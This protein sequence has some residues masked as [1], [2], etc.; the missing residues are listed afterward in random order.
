[1]TSRNHHGQRG[2]EFAAEVRDELQ[3]EYGVI[4]KLTTTQ[5]PQV[6]SMVERAHQTIHNMIATQNIEPKQDLPGR[7][8]G[9]HPKCSSVRH[10]SYYSHHHVRNPHAVGV[11]LQCY[12]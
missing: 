1:V 3:N 2:K 5:N 9:R 4:R 8:W 11:Q 7:S 6:N 10:V 12:S